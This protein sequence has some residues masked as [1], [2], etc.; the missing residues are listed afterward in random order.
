MF[1]EIHILTK[2]EKDDGS[3]L[4]S[5]YKYGSQTIQDICILI[6]FITHRMH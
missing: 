5:M 4:L 1:R 6:A 2:E 3:I